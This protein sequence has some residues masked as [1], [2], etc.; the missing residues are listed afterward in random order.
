MV[1]SDWLPVVIVNMPPLIAES[2]PAM[3][4]CYWIEHVIIC[5]HLPATCKPSST[6]DRTMS[7]VPPPPS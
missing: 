5:S 1:S 6:P 3:V 4:A 2:A 7:L